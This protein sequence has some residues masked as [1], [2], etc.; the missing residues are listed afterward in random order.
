[1]SVDGREAS[2]EALA[3][4]V[5]E[6]DAEA[7][8]ALY[9]LYARPVYLFAAYVLGP[10]EAEEVVQEVFL[11]LWDKAGQYDRSRGP[12]GAWFMAVARHRVLDELRHRGKEGRVLLLDPVDE[13]LAETPDDGVAVE[14]QALTRDRGHE[15]LRAVRTLPPEQ[16]RVLVL[17]YFGG[18][19]HA[20]IAEAL[21]WP[22]GTVKKRLQLAVRKLRAALAP[23]LAEAVPEPVR[24]RR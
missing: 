11:S 10:S 24:R 12:F 16:R 20:A 22:L 2:E 1:M 17:A 6:R 18:L 7:F 5:S 23:E 3:A 8:A 4:R 13:L 15:V 14:E 19:T 9:D 21:G